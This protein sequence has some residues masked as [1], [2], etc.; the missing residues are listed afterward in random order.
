[1]KNIFFKILITISI[2]SLTLISCNKSEVTKGNAGSPI[3]EKSM[4]APNSAMSWKCECIGSMTC[5]VSNDVS[6]CSIMSESSSQPYNI[7]CSCSSC[8]MQVTFTNSSGGI[9][10]TEEHTGPYPMDFLEEFITYSNDTYGTTVEMVSAEKL[11]DGEDYMVIFEYS[12]PE[13]GIGSIA[14]A[15]TGDK[16][17]QFECTGSC[18]SGVADCRERFVLASKSIECTCTGCQMVV[19]ELAGGSAE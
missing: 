6:Y 1:M 13:G 17:Y 9:I 5:P 12:T 7:I 15:K 8:I 11:V 2:L 3:I 14:F 18:D 4:F 16:K 10:S 19:T